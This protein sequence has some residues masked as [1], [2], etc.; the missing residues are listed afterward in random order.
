MGGKHKDWKL[1]VISTTGESRSVPGSYDSEAGAHRAAATQLQRIEK[2]QPASTHGDGAKSTRDRIYIVR[3]D[4]TKYR[5]QGNVI[6]LR[7]FRTIPGVIKSKTTA[8]SKK[9][10]P[11][12]EACEKELSASLLAWKLYIDKRRGRNTLRIVDRRLYD[13]VADMIKLMGKT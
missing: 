12:I 4:K 13:A 8:G 2:D 7:G 3:P 11:E 6:P 9:K 1:E 5:F 10:T